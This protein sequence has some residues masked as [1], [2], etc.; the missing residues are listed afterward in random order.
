MPAKPI[1]AALPKL[2]EAKQEPVRDAVKK[3]MVGF[4]PT[5][6]KCRCSHSLALRCCW[7]TSTPHC[8]LGPLQQAVAQKTLWQLAF[9]AASILVQQEHRMHSDEH[10]SHLSPVQVELSSWVGVDTVRAI[11]GDKMPEAMRKDFE[12][13]LDDAGAARKAPTRFTRAVQASLCM[14]P[15]DTHFSS[16]HLSA[17]PA[18]LASLIPAQKAPPGKAGAGLWLK[19]RAC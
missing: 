15:P 18:G 13:I 11:L 6:Q 17:V 14:L 5:L 10:S 9:A 19:Q 8:T 7:M 16:L 4:R 1:L 12:R 2:F 3:L